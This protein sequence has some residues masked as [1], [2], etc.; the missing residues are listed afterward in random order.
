MVIKR[1]Q[2]KLEAVE[3]SRA[4]NKRI[5]DDNRNNV[6]IIE[7]T[8]KGTSMKLVRRTLGIG[9]KQLYVLKDEPGQIKFNRDEGIKVTEA[10]YRKLH[11]SNDL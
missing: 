5:T 10:F 9:R 1:R 2:D 7:E 8:K 11:S 4:I 6:K 3:L